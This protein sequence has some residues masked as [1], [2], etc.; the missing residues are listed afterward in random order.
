MGAQQELNAGI[1]KDVVMQDLENNYKMI[2]KLN[3]NNAD[4][5]RNGE[6]DELVYSKDDIENSLVECGAAA[7]SDKCL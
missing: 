4:K 6:L 5:I 2:D 1:S 3:E 7:E